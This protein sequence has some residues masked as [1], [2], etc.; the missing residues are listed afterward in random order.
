LTL[1]FLFCIIK[2]NIQSHEIQHDTSCLWIIW[3]L[4]FLGY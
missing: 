1:S 2:V 4:F 3:L